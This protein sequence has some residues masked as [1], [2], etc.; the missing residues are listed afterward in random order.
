M[1][2]MHNI[3][4]VAHYE[5]K[6]LSRSW[7][8][9]LFL[10]GSLFIL[11]I[12]N[13]GIYSP[14]GDEDWMLVS[15]P[16]SVPLINL[17]L[18][19]IGQA[20]V[21]IFL[22][23]DFLKRDKKVDTNE[24][25]YTRPMS[26]FEYVVGKSWGI[27]RLFL[28]LDLIILAIALTVNIIS[29]SM[30]V[31]IL[32]YLEYLL[33]ISI[34]TIVFS[35]GLA[36]IL[37][38]V[39]KNQALTFLILLGIAA[40]DMFWLWYRAGSIFDYMAFGLPLYK[41]GI[42]GFSNVMNIIYQ[43]LSFLFAG[44]AMVMATILIFKRLP[45]SKAHTIAAAVLL[46]L[47]LAGGLFSAYKTWKVY[48]DR[49]REVKTIM[50]TNSKYEKRSFVSIPE[51]EIELKH[52][53]KTIEATA[54][55]KALNSTLSDIDTLIF[56]LNPGL[57]VREISNSKGPLE[58]RTDNHLIFAWCGT[59]L[60]EGDSAVVTLKYSG[61][62]SETFCF[63]ANTENLKDNPY[64]IAMVNL[65]KRQAF[66]ANDYILLTPESQWYPVAGLNYYP[67]NPA[68]MK[69]DFTRYKLKASSSY[70]L[71]VVSQGHQVKE[72]DYY[73]YKPETPLTGLTVAMGN[74]VS[75]TLRA[76]NTDFIAW[77]YPGN[78]YYKEALPQL[79]DTLRLLA[80]GFMTELENTFS[81]KY[82]FPTLSLVEVPVQYYSYPMQST[83]T[84]SELQP[85]MVLVP[86]KLATIEGA[87]FARRFKRQKRQAQRNNQVVTDKELQVR[88]FNNF[89]RN[90]FIY[91]ENFRFRN[92]AV[93]NEPTRYRLGPSFYYFV[94]NFRSDEYPILNAAFESHLQKVVNP[95]RG[96]WPFIM[97]GQISENDMA[98]LT[99]RNTSMSEL[100]SLKPSDD[101]V[102]SIL[103]VK[104][105]YLFNL[106]RKNAGRDEFS[107]WFKAYLDENKF[108]SINILTFNEVIKNK[109]GFDFYSHLNNW[110]NGKEQPGFLISNITLKEIVIKD[111]SR[112]QVT[113]IASNPEK[114]G[115]LFNVAF[116]TGG[117]GGRGVNATAIVDRVGPGGGGGRTQTTMQG[118]GLEAADIEGI[119]FLKPGEAKKIGFV[120]DN[121]PRVM[122]VN[123]LFS[124]N[125]PGEITIGMP[126]LPK[127]KERGEPFE[128]ETLLEK[129]PVYTEKGEI[130]VDNEDAGFK[131]DSVFGENRLRKILGVKSR[132][133]EV[134]GI[135]NEY[136]APY[137]W[138]PVI[139]T[140][141]FGK[142]IRSAV[143]T[144]KGTGDRSVT[145]KG[146]IEKPGYYDIYAYIPKE[147][148]QQFSRQG[149]GGNNPE[150]RESLFRDLHF[151]VYHDD[152]TE[153]LTV[154]F[155]NAEQGWN[156]LG[157]YYL[158]P[159]TVKVSL[160]NKTEGR[161]VIGDAIRW[162]LQQ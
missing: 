71:N 32:A 105:D 80:N 124:K 161:M 90:T 9:R 116:R 106:L 159:D 86:E 1:S 8:F 95:G 97:S 27:L 151:T 23:A 96:Q 148:S 143:Y 149:Q 94:N 104:G 34:P 134:Y 66:L 41:S 160:S 84:R 78:D 128:G 55:L 16:S 48:A 102:R 133:G 155:E 93:S 129:L 26:N 109:F 12:M 144:R 35:L 146:I 140:S 110:Y 158:S 114:E 53:G 5:A 31:E 152:G 157:T 29:K 147:G 111:R 88:I 22:A 51:A 139:Q 76:G 43:R 92:G 103:T 40:L 49:K 119:V 85:S 7:F 108:R 154:D 156:K 62:I 65:E 115:G 59:P 99:L 98:N 42:A 153:E 10:A 36:F 21:V 45:Q 123:S 67:S 113:F 89:T 74:Y 46:I 73:I 101:T 70:K 135:V 24:V 28:I 121:Q 33:I 162:V 52:L 25:L 38:S 118:R 57:T 138:Q 77:H 141:Y 125:L 107:S 100:M 132:R 14:V 18:L 83:Q 87:G 126:D 20:I 64:R 79:K 63:P 112:Y 47:F 37:M 17:Y 68:K 4:T 137:Y 50:E 150:Q 131:R 142:F 3:S 13:I 11:T 117:P 69:V 61:K 6:T 54:T 91:G 72:G 127:S 15:I 60:E 122:I 120:L 30:K 81:A 58:F 39:I 19:N 75:D 145:W 82:P 56:S 44:L 130:I 136:N 2:L